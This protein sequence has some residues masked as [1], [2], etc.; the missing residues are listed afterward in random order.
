MSHHNEELQAVFVHVPKAAGTS[1]SVPTWNRGNGHK[2]VADYEHQLGP[3]FPL[4]FVWA[5]VRNPY[6]RIVSAYEDCPE[7]FPHAPTFESFVGQIHLHRKQLAGLRCLRETGVPRFGF[8][9]GRL[10]FQPMHLLLQDKTGELRPHFIGKFERLAADFLDL[11]QLLGIDPEPLAHRNKRADKPRRR[12]SRW[13][14]LYTAKVAAQVRD[15][16]AHDF[17]LFGYPLDFPH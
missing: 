8:P 10:H 9:I 12:N 13:Q 14:D 5:F 17:D 15:I 1:L 7:I 6:D 3:K 2:T 16:Y 11:Q 4:H